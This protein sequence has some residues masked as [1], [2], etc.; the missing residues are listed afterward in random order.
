M[1]NLVP[2]AMI[3]NQING[4]KENH[5]TLVSHHVVKLEPSAIRQLDPFSMAINAIY[6]T[7]S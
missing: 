3:N 1:K 7:S 6:I 5:L 2:I 4:G